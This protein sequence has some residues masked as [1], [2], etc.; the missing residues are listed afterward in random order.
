MTNP[1]MQGMRLIDA[2]DLKYTRVR[3]F[4]GFN[5]DGSPLVG[6]WNAVVMSCA[7]KEAQT[8]DAVKVIR[9]K[10]CEFYM[11]ET[12]ERCNALKIDPC[13]LCL[14]HRQLSEADYREYRNWNDFCSCGKRRESNG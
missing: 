6:G 11:A 10:D 7:I 9:C 1:N 13:G 14:R 12:E 5:D 4:H 3:I 2:N 8:V